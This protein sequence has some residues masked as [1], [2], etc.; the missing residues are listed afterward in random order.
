M[1]ATLTQRTGARAKSSAA[2]EAAATASTHTTAPVQAGDTGNIL[3]EFGRVPDVQRLYGLKRGYLYN[4]IKEGKVRSV[5]LRKPGAKTG[6]RLIHLQSVRDFLLEHL[7][8]GRGGKA[9]AS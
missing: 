9:G 3:P 4:L 1:K 8:S 6:C 5:C 2:R 7:D